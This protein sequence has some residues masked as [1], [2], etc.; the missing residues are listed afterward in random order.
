MSEVWEG[1]FAW[2]GKRDTIR[3]METKRFNF[4]HRV[5]LVQWEDGS[6][7]VQ[8]SRVTLETI[9]IRTQMGDSVK[10]IHRGYPTVSVSQIKEIVAWY[11]DNKADVDE[12]IRQGQEEVERILQRI[13]S[14]PGYKKVSREELLRRKAQLIKT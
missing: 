1:L 6:V 2:T 9:V 7:S 14:Q 11:F 5:P 10:R 13:E 8:N 4:P 12:Y 3:D